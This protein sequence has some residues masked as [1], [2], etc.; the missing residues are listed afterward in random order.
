[1]SLKQVD[2]EGSSTKE[3]VQETDEIVAEDTIDQKAAP[4]DFDSVDGNDVICTGSH[5]QPHPLS[6]LQPLSQPQPQ[7]QTKARTSPYPASGVARF[8]VPDFFVHWEVSL[9]LHIWKIPTTFILLLIFYIRKTPQLQMNYKKLLPIKIGFIHAFSTIRN[10][11]LC[12]QVD[13]HLNSK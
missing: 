3:A 2:Q 7:L 1:M 10:F 11:S 8:P 13:F 5:S 9:L 6:H 4:D 12:F